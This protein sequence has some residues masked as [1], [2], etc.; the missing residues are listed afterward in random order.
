MNFHQIQHFLNV[1]LAPF[2]SSSLINDD[3][4]LIASC[5]EN[6]LQSST[7]RL[8]VCQIIKKY[9]NPQI[10]DLFIV[11]DP[12]NGGLN[13]QN[14]FFVSKLT[15]KLYLVFVQETNHINFKIPPTPLY[16]KSAKN[17]TIWPLLVEQNPHGA[18]LANFFESKW[19]QVSHLQ[20]FKSFFQMIS[21]PKNLQVYFKNIERVF[22]RQFNNRALGQNE[23]SYKINATDSIKLKLAIDEKQNQRTIYADFSQSS[24]AQKISAASHIVESCLVKALA[25]HYGMTEIL[26]QPLLD[27]IRLTLPPQSI[28]SKANPQGS[29]NLLIQKIVTEQAGFLLS[30]LAGQIKSKA[31]VFKLLP[32]SRM[33]LKIAEKNYSIHASSKKFVFPQLD[34]LIQTHQVMPTAMQNLEGKLKIKLQI[35]TTEPVSLIP[36][37]LNKECPA[38]FLSIG[39]VPVAFD[40]EIKITQNETIEINWKLNDLRA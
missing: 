23:V 40:S 9:L 31:V 33:I 7:S 2:Q 29:H 27:R 39:G 20:S 18:A 37:M 35:K 16:E 13:Y 6:I 14:I 24:S 25:D 19:Q 30:T 21:I 28:V 36:M 10:G 8:V 38:D 22:D 1:M 26:S 12:D 15:E 11:N 5:D 34:Y 3:G 17:K 4:K 32:E